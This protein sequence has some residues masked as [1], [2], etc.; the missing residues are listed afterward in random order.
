MPTTWEALPRIALAST[1]CS[2]A[3]VEFTIPQVVRLSRASS[4]GGLPALRL[5]PHRAALMARMLPVQSFITVT[6]FCAVREMHGAV[7]LVLGETPLNLPLSYGLASV[8]LIAAK[9][10]LV[11]EGVYR[12]HGAA[13][14]AGGCR[15]HGCRPSFSLRAAARFFSTKI[16][17]GL[18]WSYVRDS[19]G[20]G[21]GIV[22]GPIL[23]E[24]LKPALSEVDDGPAKQFVSK[25]CGGLVAGSISGFATQWCHNT[26]LEA[27]RVTEAE[28]RVPGTWESLRRVF[29]EHGAR[30]FTLNFRF[31]VA[32]IASWTAI[33]TVTEPFARK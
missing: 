22:L 21:G 2:T 20:I 13:A 8:P 7:D 15:P 29:K 16:R 24:Q 23:A 19:V 31:R 27:G 1:L 9:Y 12:H 32:I 25:F 4:A 18:L 5:F 28:G 33:L 11:V 14:S 30:A 17:P 6:Q 10:N 26:A 3:I